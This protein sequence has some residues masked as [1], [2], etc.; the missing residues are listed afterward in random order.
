MP[1]ACHFIKSRTMSS[2]AFSTGLV[3]MLFCQ[4]RSRGRLN[5]HHVPGCLAAHTDLSSSNKIRPLSLLSATLSH[6][7][8]RRP[9]RSEHDIIT[10]I[11]FFVQVVPFVK[12]Y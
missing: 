2:R 9:A 5:D 1:L 10:R 7:L 12:W 6:T 8:I 4:S 11:V 3:L